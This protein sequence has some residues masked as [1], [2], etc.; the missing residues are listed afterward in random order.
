VPI[1]LAA[2]ERPRFRPTVSN[3]IEVG[4]RMLLEEETLEAPD[5]GMAMATA[6]QVAVA[7]LGD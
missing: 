3:V 4:A 6:A 1:A 5:L 2:I 7:A